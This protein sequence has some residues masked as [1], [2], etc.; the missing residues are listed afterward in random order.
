MVYLGSFRLEVYNDD[1]VAVYIVCKQWL[2]RLDWLCLRL[3]DLG[4]GETLRQLGPRL[5][6]S[7]E[8]LVRLNPDL[9]GVASLIA[10]DGKVSREEALDVILDLDLYTNPWLEVLDSVMY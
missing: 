8:V 9:E 1:M 5:V 3:I 10:A 2:T 7:G 4:A 6:S